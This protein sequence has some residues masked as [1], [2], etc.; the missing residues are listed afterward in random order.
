MRPGSAVSVPLST[1]FLGSAILMTVFGA[2]MVANM[3]VDYQAQQ[4]EFEQAKSAMLLLAT[5]AEDVSLKPQS[6]SH[7]IVHTRSG[8]LWFRSNQG[9]FQ[10]NITSGVTETTKISEQVNTFAYLAGSRAQTVGVT[11]LRGNGSLIMKGFT[12]PLGHVFTNQ[13]D[14]AWVMLDGGR[15]RVVRHGSFIAYTQAGGTEKVNLAEITFVR[16][17][18]G[19]F[20]GS[21][22]LRMRVENLGVTTT[23]YRFATN[24]ITVEATRG[25]TES[26]VI[27][28][29]VDDVATVVNLVVANVKV[30]VS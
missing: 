25:Q 6:A 1:V 17:Q 22:T 20:S 8:G 15:V 28:G 26:Y 4:V 29:A 27:T 30:S 24:S 21:G 12:E 19:G 23:A 16:L 7:A 10:L 13:S 5:S 14:G 18:L 11:Y 2:V 9:L 3:A